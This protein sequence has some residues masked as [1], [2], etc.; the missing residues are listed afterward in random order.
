[1][2]F[3]PDDHLLWIH[4]HINEIAEAKAKYDLM[5]S[6]TKSIKADLM[7]KFEGP[8]S[9]REMKALASDEYKEHLIKVYH[10]CETLERLKLTRDYH[11]ACYEAWRTASSNE[12]AVANTMKVVLT[13]D[14]DNCQVEYAKDIP[15]YTVIQMLEGALNALKKDVRP[16]TV[17]DLLRD[18]PPSKR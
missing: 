8:I 16:R 3:D 11:M 10:A 6:R 15:I 1:M 9:S 7:Q 17:E 13:K 5:D 14:G 18:H 2:N 12:R 4:D